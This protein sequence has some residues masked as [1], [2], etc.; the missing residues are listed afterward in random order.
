MA[1]AV[2][3]TLGPKGRNVII[4][5]AYGSPKIT[6]DGVTVAKAITFKD[7]QV[8]LGA[9]LVKSVASKT[10]DIA[11]DGTTTATILTR[12][13]FAEGCKAVAAGMN[14][15]DIRRGM[16]LAVDKVVEYLKSI[17]KEITTKEEIAQVAT[18]SANGD[19]VVGNLI[20]DAMERVGKEGVI[21]VQDGKTLYDELEVVEGMKFDR[22]F[23]SPYFINNPKLQVVE[24]EQPLI[25]VC[26][27][28]ISQLQ[29]LLPLLEQVVKSG[30]PFLIIAED[31]EGE[32]LATLIVNKLRGSAKMAAVKAPGFGDN[33]KA[34]LQDLAILTGAQLISDEIGIKLEDVTLDM[35][36]SALKITANKDET[37]VL[38]GGGEKED[39]ENRCELLRAS[40]SEST[41]DYSREQVQTRLAKLSGG[42]AVIKVGGA[43]EVE[44]GEKKDRVDDAL[45]ATRAAVEEGIVPGGGMALLYSSNI[46]ANLP[47]DNSDQAVG[48]RIVRDAIKVPAKTIVQNAGMQGEVV[49]GNLLGKAEAAG[50]SVAS[51]RFGMDASTGLMVDMVAAGIIDPTKV[52]RTALVDACGVASLMTTTECMIV[53]DPG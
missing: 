26:E 40:I 36:G 52:V 1:D 20:A 13:F 24:F 10:N 25:L 3:V 41:S 29:S 6:K 28:K 45:N 44:V 2:Q 19:K 42:V 21:T 32:A 43:S 15:M 18:I 38:G 37:I 51:T 48:V 49:V 8:N 4:D 34:M 35:L 53:D 5:Q 39:I 47:V 12:A 17:S 30:R 22:G 46:L 7:K 31:L 23:I 14:P 33:R 27:K 16:V 11:G 9:N 50:F